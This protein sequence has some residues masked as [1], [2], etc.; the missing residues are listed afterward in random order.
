MWMLK[1][2]ND[3]LSQNCCELTNSLE[4]FETSKV[5]WPPPTQKLLL[6]AD[7]F[8]SQYYD[9]P[10]MHITIIIG[11]NQPH[12]NHWWVTLSLSCLLL[13]INIIL[14]I[15]WHCD[16]AIFFL[17]ICLSCGDFKQTHPMN[18]EGQHWFHNR[19]ESRT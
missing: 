16:I 5:S 18:R 7:H 6:L 2:S 13:I 1:L 9:K 14:I 19:T 17:I 4:C 11:I 3:F 12:S 8:I 10:F 15:S